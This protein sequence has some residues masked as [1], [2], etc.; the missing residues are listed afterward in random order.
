MK[1]SDKNLYLIIE[2]SIIRGRKLEKYSTLLSRKIVQLLKDQE[3]RDTLSSISPDK[4]IQLKN[5]LEIDSI[6]SDLDNIR[7]F[8]IVLSTN[9]ENYADIAGNYVFNTTNRENSDFYMVIDL[10]R[11]Y[12]FSLFSILIPELKETIRHELEHSSDDTETLSIPPDDKWSSLENLLDHFISEAETKAYV[13]G[14]YKKAK[15]TKSSALD[16]I[17]QYLLNVYN[18]AI[19]LG[20]SRNDLDPI[21]KKIRDRWVD[22]LIK[23]YPKARLNELVLLE[24]DKKSPG[25]GIVVVRKIDNEWKV[26][27]LKIYGRYDIPKGKI[28]SGESSLDA[29]V[30]ETIEEAGISDL[31]FRWGL[32]SIKANHVTLYIAQ[33][34]QEGEIKPN[35]ETGIYEHHGIK[36]MS[37]EDLQYNIHPYLAHAISWAKD[38]VE[39]QLTI[40][41]RKKKKKKEKL[42]KSGSHPEE[43]YELGTK[44]NLYLDRPTSHGGWPEGPSKSFTSNKPVNIQ[45]SSWL[46]NMGMMEKNVLEKIISRI[47]TE[48]ISYFGGGFANFKSLIDSGIHPIEAAEESGFKRVQGGYS[49]FVYEHPT[50][51]EFVLKIAHGMGNSWRNANTWA[52]ETADE[53]AGNIDLARRTNVAEAQSGKNSLFDIFPKV[54]PGDP[55]GNWILS[56]KV[57][58][59]NSA[60]EMSEF[61]PEI[62]FPAGQM[63]WILLL[64]MGSK[65]A[66]EMKELHDVGD[67]DAEPDKFNKSVEQLSTNPMGQKV[68]QKFT[69]LWKNP[70][71]REVSKAMSYFGIAPHEMRYDNVGYVMRDKKKQFVILDVSVGLGGGSSENTTEF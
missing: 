61:F 70:T 63:M 50:A 35:P 12:E 18:I 54:Y 25:A 71:F 65:Y 53:N 31:N 30:R 16:V 39:S 51:G 8:Y 64:D 48:N 4:E 23:R 27:G 46:K 7:D 3:I 38:I 68:V 36:W 11:D 19:S 21:M 1:V 22:Y 5:P 42:K 2:S 20:Y 41:E 56:E 66:K 28:E 32:S 17:D 10:P 13:T 47:L 58:T 59:L 9:D 40:N 26:L 60:K 45:I 33:T 14:L 69:E 24:E 43:A 6:I 34:S 62:S 67:W 44:K 15:M 57:N 55:E 29:A 37:W 49:R 52:D